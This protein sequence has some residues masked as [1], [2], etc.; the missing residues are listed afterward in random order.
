MDQKTWKPNL[1][2]QVFTF[3]PMHLCS[4]CTFVLLSPCSSIRK[5]RQM[6]KGDNVIPL[7]AVAFGKDRRL[8][9]DS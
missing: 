6:P 8:C 9:H 3:V 2:L 5:Q 4:F 7:R 1:A